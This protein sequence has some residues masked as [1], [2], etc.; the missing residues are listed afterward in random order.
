MRSFFSFISVSVAAPDLDDSHA[1]G[2]LAR[3]S[4]SFSRSNSVVVVSIWLRIWP[5]GP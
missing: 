5:R 2:Q 1:A 3:R 4:C